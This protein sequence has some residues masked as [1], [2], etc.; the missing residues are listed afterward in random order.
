M[1]IRDLVREWKDPIQVV[2]IS[3]ALMLSIINFIQANAVR[4]DLQA[5]AIGD[6]DTRLPFNQQD[7]I[8][9]RLAV[10]NAGTRQAAVLQA[11]VVSLYKED[12]GQ[13]SWVRIFPA[14]GQGF[15]AKTLKPGEIEILSLVTDGYA[16]AYFKNPRYARP[17]DA[18]RHEFTEGVRIKSMDSRGN[19][20]SVLYP[21]S[22][23]NVPNDIQNGPTDGFTFDR[24]PHQLLL[25]TCECVPPLAREYRDGL[26]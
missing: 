16:H 14:I 21:I 5:T 18:T 2:G 24:R 17:I 1:S 25:N 11:E 6:V 4:D 13:Y 3:V 20:Y 8:T 22:Q 10:V 19:I 12:D 15:E 9:I 26:P 7:R 23:F